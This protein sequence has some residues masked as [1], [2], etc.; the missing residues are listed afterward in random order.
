M[1]YSTKHKFSVVEQAL[2]PVRKWLVI[3][4]IFMPQLHQWACL[5]RAVITIA[6]LGPQLAKTVDDL[7]LPV[8]CMALLTVKAR[9]WGRGFQINASSIFLCPATD[10]LHVLSNRVFLSCSAGEPRAMAKSCIILSTIRIPLTNNLGRDTPHLALGF[11]FVK[12]WLS[13]GVQPQ[14]SP[15]VRQLHSNS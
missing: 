7:S 4:K 10:V 3:P 2:N 12:L 8:H 5:A 11:L 13:G 9:W 14:P 1:V 15:N 6:C